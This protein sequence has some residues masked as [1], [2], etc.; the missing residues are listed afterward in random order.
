MICFYCKLKMEEYS[1]QKEDTTAYYWH[2]LRC[3]I[4]KNYHLVKKNDRKIRS[5]S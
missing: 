2:C 5:F 1:E 3:H 4:S